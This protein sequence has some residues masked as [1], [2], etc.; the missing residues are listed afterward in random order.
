MLAVWVEVCGHMHHANGLP[1]GRKA[2]LLA[3]YIDTFRR[4]MG[5]WRALCERIARSAFLSDQ[6]WLTLDWVLRPDRMCQLI[7]G[8][9][10]DSKPIPSGTA[11][12]TEDYGWD[13]GSEYREAIRAWQKTGIWA[14]TRYGPAPGQPFCRVPARILRELGVPATPPRVA[15]TPAERANASDNSRT[16]L[17]EQTFGLLAD[18]GNA[19]GTR[20]STAMKLT[21]EWR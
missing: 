6:S 3:R 18:E 9:H 4:D 15:P 19:T 20:T 14:H 8:K 2:A 12:P 13:M 11:R 16:C 21:T 7:E 5:Q 10:L 1:K 17:P